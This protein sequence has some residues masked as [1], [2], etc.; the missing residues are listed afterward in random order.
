M[1]QTKRK[2]R[3]TKHRGNAAGMIETRGRTGRKPTEAERKADVKKDAAAR[4]AERLNRPPTWRS[5]VNKAA[6][7][8]AVFAVAVTLLFQRPLVGSLVLALF[9]F[10]VYVPLSYFTDAMIYKRAQAKRGKA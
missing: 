6:L 8:A 5:A 9:T 2:R 10:V 3:S 4:R 1:A 7:A